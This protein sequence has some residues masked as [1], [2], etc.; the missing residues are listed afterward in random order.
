[1]SKPTARDELRT[2]LARRAAAETALES[3]RQATERGRELIEQIARE[4]ESLEAASERAS[5]DLKAEMR[6]AVASG[7]KRSVTTNDRERGK[8]DLARATMDVRRQAAEEVLAELIAEEHDYER[9][10]SG[11]KA[12]IDRAVKNVLLTEIEE[13]ARA[14]E[15]LDLKAH[16]IRI[17]LGGLSGDPV[18]N[19]S[20]F[21]TTVGKALHHNR[22]DR[23]FGSPEGGVV[24]ESWAA[25][26]TELLK[27]PDAQWDFTA[28][29][30]ALQKLRDERAAFRERHA[31][32]Q[33][34]VA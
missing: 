33:G 24:R 14:W 22:Q 15:E 1:M 12:A 25:F 16:A 10:L 30:R 8:N 5:S 11:A 6:A 18:W 27:N 4:A 32:P 29:D 28:A 19:I 13:I 2:A 21:S 7:G 3:A 9:E 20:N 23:E 34:K 17:R 26:S 31:P